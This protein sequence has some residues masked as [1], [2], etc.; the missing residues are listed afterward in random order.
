MFVKIKNGKITNINR[1]TEYTFIR[2]VEIYTWNQNTEML[3]KETI[4][5]QAEIEQYKD[6]DL[7]EMIARNAMPLLSGSP[8]YGDATATRNADITS[9]YNALEL[10]ETIETQ[11]RVDEILAKDAENNKNDKKDDT[12]KD[13]DKDLNDGKERQ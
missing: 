1:N 8:K 13:I 7:K 11:K 10:N 12:I 5:Q 6:C 2:N 3:E 4:D 9:L